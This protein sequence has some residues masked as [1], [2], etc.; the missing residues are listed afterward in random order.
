MATN[1]YNVTVPEV[2]LIADLEVYLDDSPNNGLNQPQWGCV[3]YEKC[4]SCAEW[5]DLWVVSIFQDRHEMCLSCYVR[6]LNQWRLVENKYLYSY[7][8][9]RNPNTWDIT[10]YERCA[11]CLRGKNPEKDFIEVQT[12]KGD[13][14]LVHDS[15]RC[16]TWC[17]GCNNVFVSLG[18]INSVGISVSFIELH[19]DYRCTNCYNEEIENNGGV[20]MYFQC[21][22]CGNTEHLDDSISRDYIPSAVCEGCYESYSYYCDDCDLYYWQ[23]HDCYSDEDSSCIHDYS[24][25]PRAYFFGEGSYHLGIELEIESMGESRSAGAQ[26]VQDALGSR[27]YIKSDGSLNDGF[28][29]VSHPHTLKEYET[30]F[31]WSILKTLREYG[32]RSWNTDT[33]GLHVHVGR[34]AFGHISSH[35]DIQK[36]QAHELRFMKLIYDNQRQVERLAGRANSHYASFQDKG[37]LV[38]KV[39]NGF[40]RN[41]RYS[42]VNTE[43][44]N[45]IEVRI[46]KGSLRKERVLS[47]IE[48]VVAAVEYTRDLKVAGSKNTLSWLHFTSYVV[49]NI[50]QY[51][52]L[53][54]N[55]EKC[56]ASD[57]IRDND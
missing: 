28:E 30:N 6:Y 55:M 16:R 1:I 4:P 31:N 29:M 44:D 32:Y 8:L 15:G 45:T 42:V 26:M 51:P 3:G 12:R 5:D 2:E 21:Y 39:K 27:V 18:H 33:C 37:H 50:E 53:A 25:K 47:A 34:V 23:D 22:E 24:Y 7:L 14:V 54:S 43:N 13:T 17:S 19:G 36:A 11:A 49:Q 41:G 38:S 10:D 48:F 46:F 20:E 56:F 9:V 52:N 35:R 40:Q 57:S